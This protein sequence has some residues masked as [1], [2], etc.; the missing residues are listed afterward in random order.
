MNYLGGTKDN[1]HVNDT[2]IQN[3]SLSVDGDLFVDGDT[4]INGDIEY[5]G[6]VTINPPNCLNTDC[7]NSATPATGIEINTEYKLPVVKGAADQ[8]L[9][10]IDAAGN[11]E[12]R[13]LTAGS[14]RVVVNKFTGTT[15]RI[16]TEAE[17]TF[18]ISI[19]QAGFGSKQYL[20]DEFSIGSVIVIRA[21][22]SWTYLRSAQAFIPEGK[23]WL[24]IGP[25]PTGPQ[26]IELFAPFPEKPFAGTFPQNRGSAGNWEL[27][28]QLTRINAT[29]FRLGGTLTNSLA[30]SQ[31]QV[32][33]PIIFPE[34][35][36]NNPDFFTFSGY[37]FDVAVKWQDNTNQGGGA[38]YIYPTLC[39]YTQDLVN[40]GTSILATSENLTTDHLLLSNLN[41]NGGDGGHVFLYDLRGLK[42][43]TG[44]MNMNNNSI[45]NL[46]NIDVGGGTLNISNTGF[47]AMNITGGVNF[48]NTGFIYQCPSLFAGSGNLDIGSDF[49]VVN[50]Q[51]GPFGSRQTEIAIIPNLINVNSP[52]TN[53]V[54]GDVYLSQNRIQDVSAID[55]GANNSINMRDAGFGNVIN[56]NSVGNGVN[57]QEQSTGNKISVTNTG[58]ASQVVSGG[59][60][61][62][63]TDA[64]NNLTLSKTNG[65][66]IIL[67]NTGAGGAITGEAE[68][69][70]FNYTTT[71]FKVRN[72]LTNNFVIE[73]T[74]VESFLN[75]V[76]PSINGLTP[77]GGLSSGTSNSATLG[78]STAEQSILA[79]TFVGS[80]QAP[81]NTFK[82]GDAYVATLAGNFSS[83]GSDTLTLRLKGGALGTTTL[84]TLVVPLNNSSGVYFELEINFVV[85]QIGAAGVAD[86]AI[87]YDFTYNQSAMGGSFSGE[88]LCENNNT[89]F[90]TEILNQLDI[91][92]QFSSTS[93]SNSIETILSTLGKTY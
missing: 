62:Q 36:G 56:I 41:G 53:F 91:T 14:A 4:I 64:G 15:S 59:T 75:F 20:S 52:I 70:D 69:I 25:P 77:V 3:G 90:D 37:P 19:E 72:G 16:R 71:N 11:T 7:I 21:Y 22:G 47:P 26:L 30:D 57:L 42:P 65:G 23:F 73:P 27:N 1:I 34:K 89:T 40:A 10:Q 18:I 88:R 46:Q 68:Q 33:I 67:Q 17:N 78:G 29:Q 45:T 55:D 80:R 6:N 92:A 31:N 28:I 81:A 51:T 24:L 50:I 48:N 66:Q 60:I 61:I 13:D 38:A 43:M 5:N 82:T 76:C 63:N 54:G 32:E 85:R 84:S 44:N 74:Q 49:G 9:T 86:L 79:S 12:F 93:G 8:V 83:D 58:L 39:G 2:E 87:N 35:T